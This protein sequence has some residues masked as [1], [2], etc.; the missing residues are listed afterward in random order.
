MNVTT[1]SLHFNISMHILHTA[2]RESLFNNQ[3]LSWLVIISFILLKLM[4]DL[5][6][7]L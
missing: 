1:L 5:G 4:C 7:V 3:K 2:E 6:V